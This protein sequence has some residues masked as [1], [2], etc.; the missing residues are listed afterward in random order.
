MGKDFFLKDG[1]GLGWLRHQQQDPFP[2]FLEVD[3]A[4]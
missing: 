4:E 3:S 1:E 2:T